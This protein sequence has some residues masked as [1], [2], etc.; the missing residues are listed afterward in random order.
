M[1]SKT[2]VLKCVI[3]SI[4]TRFGE[5]GWH[6]GESARLPPMF[7]V[8]DSRTQRHMWVEFVVGSRPCPEGFS[9]GSPVFLPPQKPTFLNSNSIGNSRA[10]GLSVEHCCLSPSL[11]KVDLFNY[12]F[13]ITKFWTIKVQIMS[14]LRI[15]SPY[16]HKEYFKTRLGCIYKYDFIIFSLEIIGKPDIKLLFLTIAIFENCRTNA[17]Q[18]K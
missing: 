9:P 1:E 10:T 15:G 13:T 14:S 4:I 5:Q 2:I 17:K 3:S 12:L 18:R 8:F 16:K 11:N 6:S 7:P